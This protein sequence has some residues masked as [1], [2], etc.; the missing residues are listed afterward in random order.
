MGNYWTHYALDDPAMRNKPVGSRN[1]WSA[2]LAHPEHVFFNNTAHTSFVKGTDARSDLWYSVRSDLLFSTGQGQFSVCLQEY[3]P[4]DEL[5]VG[6]M[7]VPVVEHSTGDGLCVG[8]NE[9]G[10]AIRTDGDV[11]CDGA[12]QSPPPGRHGLVDQMKHLFKKGVY[13]Q[14]HFNFDRSTIRF[15]VEGRVRDVEY[16]FSQPC[17]RAAVSFRSRN[18][19]LRITIDK[20]IANSTAER[21]YHNPPNLPDPA[22]A[23]IP[24]P[25]EYCAIVEPPPYF[26]HASPAKCWALLNSELDRITAA[27]MG[28]APQLAVNPPPPRARSRV[29]IFGLPGRGKTKFINTLLECK[30]NSQYTDSLS[31]R[32]LSRPAALGAVTTHI[33]EWRFGEEVTLV[34]MWG[35]RSSNNADVQALPN[36]LAGHIGEGA[37]MYDVPTPGH[38]LWVAA[39]TADQQVH[40]VVVVVNLDDVKAPDQT[41]TGIIN[42]AAERSYT[43]IIVVTHADT[44]DSRL[45][46]DP[47]LF[48]ESRGL[49]KVID[50]AHIKLNTDKELIFPILPYVDRRQRELRCEITALYAL[51]KA[52]KAARTK[53]NIP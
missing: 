16:V 19:Y 32:A 24:R 7:S 21:R 37:S 52:V 47:K 14:V 36:I 31:T 8:D 20:C 50:M 4:G 49:A 40:A 53:R 6:L 46:T 5:S 27:R 33:T 25:P 17:Y 48:Y 2:Q 1:C 39:P 3:T 28:N 42:A 10:V 45:A 29:A 9:L 22:N 13:V 12:V 30:E 44:L 38:P 26:Y 51:E 43:P 34:D 15:T 11:Y 18:K 35:L 41:I 23:A